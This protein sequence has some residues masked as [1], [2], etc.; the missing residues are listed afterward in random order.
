MNVVVAFLIGSSLGA[1]AMAF[2]SACASANKINEAYME[3]FLDGK[4]DKEGRTK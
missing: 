1:L 4:K 3:G 2:M